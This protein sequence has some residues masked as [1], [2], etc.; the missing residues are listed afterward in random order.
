MI[1]PHVVATKSYSK[2][3]FVSIEVPIESLATLT[4]STIKD[5]W[6]LAGVP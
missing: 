3:S 6:F 1:W 2:Q 4:A 5:Q